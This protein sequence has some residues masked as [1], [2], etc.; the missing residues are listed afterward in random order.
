MEQARRAIPWRRAEAAAGMR[1]SGP[2]DDR[3]RA[4]IRMAR[5]C[6]LRSLYS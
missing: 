3:G 4:W 1:A 5:L 6:I 2:N